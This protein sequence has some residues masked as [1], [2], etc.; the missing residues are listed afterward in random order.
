MKSEPPSR[1][2]RAIN[3]LCSSVAVCLLL[4]Q[5]GMIVRARFSEARYFSWAPHDVMW[6]FDLSVD[7]GGEELGHEQALRRYRIR[8]RKRHEH[9]IEHVKL[10]I[11]QFETTYGAGEG[12]NVTLTYRRNGGPMETWSW[13]E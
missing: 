11:R 6:D 7:V 5:L 1:S 4:F 2:P 12:A 13:P 3:L 9:A 8:R 10:A